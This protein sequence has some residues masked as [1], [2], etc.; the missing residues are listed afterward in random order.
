MDLS[1]RDCLAG[2]IA[3]TLRSGRVFTRELHDI[4]S[5]ELIDVQWAAHRA[6]QIVGIAVV[7]SILERTIPDERTRTFLEVVPRGA[8]RPEPKIG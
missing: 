2:E 4:T 5:Q 1:A 7:V 3:G 6:G 8:R